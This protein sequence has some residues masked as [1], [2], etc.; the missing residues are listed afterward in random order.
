MILTDE[1]RVGPYHNHPQ[2]RFYVVRKYKALLS[3]PV[4]QLAPH[5]P[6]W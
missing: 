5:K 6:N 4:G 1:D 2:L 3:M